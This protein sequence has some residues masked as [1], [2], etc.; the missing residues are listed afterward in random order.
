MA[1]LCWMLC[2]AGSQTQAEGLGCVVGVEGQRKCWQDMLLG[3]FVVPM[4]VIMSMF[5]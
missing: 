4:V 1:S 5:G 2:Y 3:R